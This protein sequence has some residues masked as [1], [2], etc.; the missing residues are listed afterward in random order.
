MKI[1]RILR[2]EETKSLTVPMGNQNYVF[3]PEHDGGPLVA[4]VKDKDHAEV[5]L[6]IP[7]GYR[8]HGSTD[9][10]PDAGDTTADATR[11]APVNALILDT[12]GQAPGGST[13]E[14]SMI[15]AFVV[16][17]AGTLEDMSDDELR[18]LFKSELNRAPNARAAR[19]TMIA[20]IEAQREQAAANA[21]KEKA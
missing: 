3:K 9:A 15:D 16:A 8:K 20:Q 7:E 6:S 2:G 18:D 13:N 19:E 1:E 11:E 4:E 10:I 17:N 5:F 21:A 12:S 14:T